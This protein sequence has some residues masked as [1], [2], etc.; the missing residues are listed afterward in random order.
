M[1][2]WGRVFPA[3]YPPTRMLVPQLSPDIWWWPT[4]CATAPT[5]VQSNDCIMYEDYLMRHTGSL[6]LCNR[7][8][9][10][11]FLKILLIYIRPSQGPSYVHSRANLSRT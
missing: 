2:F 11:G 9:Y 6:T 3:T 4:L 8:R 1:R 10:A 5:A 7:S